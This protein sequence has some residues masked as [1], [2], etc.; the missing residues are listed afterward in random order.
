M[1][2]WL[3]Y[4]MLFL[5]F[6]S[7]NVLFAQQ[8]RV[9]SP[10]RFLAL[11]DSYTI[12]QGVA[13]EDRW[14]NQLVNKLQSKGVYTEDLTIIAQTG[15]RTDRLMDAIAVQN[16][17]SNYNLVSLLIGVNNQYQGVS[18]DIYPN[19]FRQ[20]L[21]TAV[22]LCGGNKEG[23][24]V[25]SIPDYGY[26]PFGW[27]A[28]DYISPEIDKYNQINRE[29]TREMGIAYFDI[30]P[31]SREA[32][33]KPEYLAGDMLH[34]SGEMYARWVDLIVNNAELVIS[35][36]NIVGFT[37]FEEI[38]IYPNPASDKINVLVSQKAKAIYIFNNSGAKVHYS[39]PI[40][41]NEHHNIDVSNWP[42]GIYFIRVTL[43]NNETLHEKII[44]TKR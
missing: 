8:I 22:A 41:L 23:V 39:E 7:V 35:T 29:I 14:P 31:I 34:P 13:V 37:R 42:N 3:R 36:L 11:G 19:E 2:R 38:S 5:L 21:K 1:G 20:L 40:S 10:L 9:K 26:T 43:E 25:L 27:S 18:I 16:P 6:A 24:F 12:G 28:R 44:I 30:T 15:W 4:G 17:D 33:V 32:I